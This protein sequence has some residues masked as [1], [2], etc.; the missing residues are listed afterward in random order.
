MKFIHF[1]PLQVKAA[2][3]VELRRGA[4]LAGI[5][6]LAALS[7]AD[8]VLA[9]EAAPEAFLQHAAFDSDQEYFLYVPPAEAC[10]SACP[11]FIFVHGG[12]S[13]GSGDFTMWKMYADR[14]GFILL[15][16]HF[17]GRYDQMAQGED[18]RLLKIVDEVESRHSI[19][20]RRVLLSGFSYGGRFAYRF[21]MAHPDF[22]HTVAVLNSGDFPPPDKA[23]V[24]NPSRYY[25]CVG[26]EEGVY[27][28]QLR[29]EA[30]LLKAAGYAVITYNAKGTGHSIPTAS[31]THV[32]RLL[33]S[34]KT[35]SPFS[36][37]DVSATQTV[38]EP[39]ARSLPS[40]PEIILH[41]TRGGTVA[42]TLI[43]ESPE[44]VVIGWPSGKAA[45]RRELIERIEKP[46]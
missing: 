33:R 23:S 15:A 26:S 42:G 39:S 2:L 20:R 40:G 27:P 8:P 1:D 3:E 43:E 10:G 36:I 22:A 30:E 6:L 11:L 41:L 29:S 17:K 24:A 12:M 5:A 18:E 14:E 7:A 38:A 46:E 45:F 4:L 25:L 37:Q 32:L 16:P 34:M 13:S 21:S 44:E 35:G 9:D 31:V 19:D 28:Q